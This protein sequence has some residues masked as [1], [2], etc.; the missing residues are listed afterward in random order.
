LTYIMKLIIQSK[1][2]SKN[3]LTKNIQI[4][5]RYTNSCTQIQFELVGVYVAS[6][7]LLSSTLPSPPL[8][9]PVF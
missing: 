2:S 9:L 4:E 1:P 5:K 8:L 3:L 6:S 7:P